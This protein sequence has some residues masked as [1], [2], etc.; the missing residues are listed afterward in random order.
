MMMLTN[1]KMPIA[2]ISVCSRIRKDLGDISSLA[3]NIKEIGLLSPIIISNDNKLLAGERRLE[4]C[5][6][7]GWTEIDCIVKSTSDAE[8]D[9]SVELAE[10]IHRKDFTR[11]ELINIGIELE[12]IEKVKSEERIKSHQ[13]GNTTAKENFPEPSNGQTRDVVAKKLGMSGKQYEREKLIVQN[14]ELLSPG[15]YDDWN[16]RIKSTNAIYKIVKSLTSPPPK[17]SNQPR[18]VIR[19]VVKEV[20]PDDYE[21]LKAK[22]CRLET[23]LAAKEDEVNQLTNQVTTNGDQSNNEATKLYEELQSRYNK[24]VSDY[25]TKIDTMEIELEALRRSTDS[26]TTDYKDGDEIFNF[27]NECNSFLNKVVS[28]RYGD[29]FRNMKAEDRPLPLNALANSCGK[30]IDALEELVKSIQ[31]EDVIDIY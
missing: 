6:S 25:Q 9:L 2:N 16:N 30:I 21:D 10:N 24:E 7:L 3:M 5:K 19:E 20:V 1:Q 17:V 13:F 27:C 28:L 22:I 12:R 8:Q 29:S 23:S 11:E 14:K 15:D 26:I 18:E 4:A 31:T